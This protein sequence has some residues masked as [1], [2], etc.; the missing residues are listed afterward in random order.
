M[1]GKFK[2]ILVNIINSS[3][4]AKFKLVNEF[5]FIKSKNIIRKLHNKYLGQ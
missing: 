5:R 3:Y 2:K 1:I 4:D